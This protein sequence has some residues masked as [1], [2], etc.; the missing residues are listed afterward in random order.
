MDNHKKFCLQVKMALCK[1][2][3][4]GIAEGYSTDDTECLIK[5]LNYEIQKEMEEFESGENE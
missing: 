1:I 4:K 2:Y 3:A 5:E